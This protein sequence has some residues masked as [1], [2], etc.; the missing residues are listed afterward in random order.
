MKVQR[1]IHPVGQGAFYSE[2]LISDSGKKFTVV[3]DCGCGMKDQI[4]QE[5]ESII[6][7]WLKDIDQIDILFLSHF[8]NDHINGFDLLRNKAKVV[9]LPYISNT[10]KNAMNQVKASINSLKASINSSNYVDNID[11]QNIVNFNIID[12]SLYPNVKFVNVVS[13]KDNITEND[14]FIPYDQNITPND[15]G[16]TNSHFINL[17]NDESSNTDTNIFNIHS[18]DIIKVFDWY[19]LPFTHENYSYDNDLS[20]AINELNTYIKGI[21]VITNAHIK[22]IKNLYKAIDK[23]L[24][25][26][27]MLMFSSPMSLDKCNGSKESN[28]PSCLYTG[29]IKLADNKINQL[30]STRLG[31]YNIGT[32]QVPHHGSSYSWRRFNT[33]TSVSNTT[34]HTVYFCSHGLHNFYNHPHKAVLYDFINSSHLLYGINENPTTKM[35]QV[36]YV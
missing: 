8:H 32:L 11:I 21:D 15:F 25:N 34:S 16:N 10:I 3:Y 4:P 19:F 5:V 18:E 9:V 24:N 20:N 1:I 30:I 6:E 26:T 33:Q 2:Q 27:S 7:E 35:V 12:P 28:S 14:L 29:D 31:K 22:E 36:F 23:N 17:L 13:P